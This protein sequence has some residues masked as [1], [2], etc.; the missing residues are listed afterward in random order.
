MKIKWGDPDERYYQHGLDRGVLYPITSEPVPWN[1]LVGFDEST[2]GGVTELYYRDG[3][4]YLADAEP[5]D[6]RGQINA[7]MY[8]DV[9]NDHIGLVRAT[10]GLYVD[11]Q[12]Q[13]PF[14]FA[15]RSLVGSGTRGDMFG[16]Q[17]HL[18]Y[19]CMATIGTRSRRTIGKDTVPMEFTFDLVCTPIRL[20]G[21][22][23]TAHYVI[24]TRGMDGL[25][26]E[27]LEN[28]LYGENDSMEEFIDEPVSEDVPARMPTPTELYDIMHAGASQ[29]AS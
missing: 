11:N 8:P 4:I 16:Y 24:D 9:F 21:Y 19:N 15:Y 2:E 29:L 10:T 26:V 6:F 27:T 22:R 7:I 5:G 17:I 3:Q 28:I 25:V 1:G 23:P 12:K 20:P 18:V 14:H 13:R